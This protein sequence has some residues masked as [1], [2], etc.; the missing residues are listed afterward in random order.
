MDRAESVPDGREL[1]NLFCRLVAVSVVSPSINSNTT[2]NLIPT[3][4]AP[5][6]ANRYR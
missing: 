1:F 6:G 2:N 4:T 3:N 5:I